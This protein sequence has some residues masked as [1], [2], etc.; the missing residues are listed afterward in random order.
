MY[1]SETWSGTTFFFW[2]DHGREFIFVATCRFPGPE[3]ARVRSKFCTGS[4]PW[5]RKRCD[6]VGSIF[7]A[8]S[9]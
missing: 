4:E 1:F 8:C 6:E 9:F 3:V 7:F 2:I 5:V